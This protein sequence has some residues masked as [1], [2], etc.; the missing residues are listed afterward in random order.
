MQT[1]APE[2]WRTFGH[3]NVKSILNKQIDAKKF[4][5]AYLFF[6][7][8]G[9]G[10]KTLALEFAQRVLGA[11]NLNNHP[12]FAILDQPGE[13]TM[14][15]ILDFIS[16][17]SYKP[18]FGQ[19]KVA[20]INNAQNLNLQSSNALLKT[21]EEASPSTVIILIADSARL[22]PTIVSRCQVLN[23]SAFG[24]N[25]L[26][27]FAKSA[28]LTMNPAIEDLSFGRPA[29][30]KKLAGDKEFLSNEGKTVEQYKSFKKMRLGEKLISLTGLAELETQDLAT[31]L[32]TWLMWQKGRLSE[33]PGDYPKVRALGEGLMGLKMNK[34]KKLILQGLLLRI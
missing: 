22:L 3:P 31:N 11:E 14:E 21:L 25:Q 28:G 8:E 19:K 32:L 1:S 34:N 24:K 7:P 13:I 30:L 9:V 12:D 6:G 26:A 33:N 2:N 20:V 18:F 10:K 16:R 23:F 27:E 5:H 15:L 29:R 4:P 17:L